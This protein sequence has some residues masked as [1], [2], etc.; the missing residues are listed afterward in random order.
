[1]DAEPGVMG[2]CKHYLKYIAKFPVSGKGQTPLL[3]PM[4]EFWE[5]LVWQP[6]PEGSYKDTRPDNDVT[7]A[8][9]DG[10]GGGWAGGGVVEEMPE[11]SVVVDVLVLE[12]VLEM[13]IINY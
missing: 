6:I 12:L 8:I 13:E 10:G 7:V 4:P 1:M 9:G 11:V 2:V 3:L 5:H